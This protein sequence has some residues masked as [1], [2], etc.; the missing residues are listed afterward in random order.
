M[1]LTPLATEVLAGCMGG[2]AKTLALYP[3]DTI[4]TLR[5]VGVAKQLRQPIARYYAGCG[6]ALLGVLPYAVIFHTAFWLCESLL[7]AAPAYARQICAATCGSIAAALVGV[8]FECIKHRLQ[9][10]VVGFETPRKALAATLRHEGV[11]GLYSGLSSTLARNIPYNALHF[12][13]FRIV[14]DFLRRVLYMG[15]SSRTLDV[16]AGAVAGVI[17]AFLTTPIDLINTRL[18]T[19]MLNATV[20]DRTASNFTGIADA[21]LRIVKEEGAGSLMNGA[22]A[23]MAQYAHSGII[24]FLIYEAVKRQ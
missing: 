24:F 15:V 23:R 22:N 20:V 8:P 3:L 19:Q 18:Q 14:S 17:T 4:T 6:V 11:R 7:L 9:L 1:K 2:G 16:I 5:E 12:G 10:N 13:A 21:F